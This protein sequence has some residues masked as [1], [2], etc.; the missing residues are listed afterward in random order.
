MEWSR[1]AEKRKHEKTSRSHWIDGFSR[2]IWGNTCVYYYACIQPY[3]LG[4]YFQVDSGLLYYLVHGE[5]SGLVGV[6]NGSENLARC[7][8]G[9]LPRSAPRNSN[10][11]GDYSRISL[12]GP[13]IQP[14]A[15][16]LRS[17]APSPTHTERKNKHDY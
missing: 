6:V 11:P 8:R 10:I 14:Q 17:T 9:N 7:H 2:G 13:A 4:I 3:T 15:N 16:V 12:R 5:R 1:M